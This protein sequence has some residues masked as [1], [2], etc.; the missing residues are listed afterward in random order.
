MQS[1][2]E[3]RAAMIALRSHVATMVLLNH[4]GSDAEFI[5]IKPSKID[6]A[7]VISRIAGR[8]LRRVGVCGVAI[9]GLGAACHFKEPLNSSVLSSIAT[10]FAD[11][12]RVATGMDCGDAIATA[13]EIEILE[14]WYALPDPRDSQV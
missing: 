7:E 10:A 6:E 1:S 8:G 3:N 11:Y 9:G 5:C 12:A 2:F 4:D 14:R 13:F